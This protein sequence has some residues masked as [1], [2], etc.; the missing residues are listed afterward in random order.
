M[1]TTPHIAMAQINPVVGD[2]EYNARKILEYWGNA[3]SKADLVVFPELSVSGY[4]PEDLVLKPF[5]MEKMKHALEDILQKSAS[6]KSAALIGCPWE[7]DGKTHNAVHLIENSK[8]TA[9]VTKHHLP[10]YGVFDEQR[11]F[12][13]GPLPGP[14]NF[15][16]ASLGIMI[17]EDMW[18]PDVAAHLKDQGADLFIVPNAS[19]FEADKKHERLSYAR[20]R[21]AETGLK[22]IYVNQVGGQD[23]LVF[24]GHSFVMD[25]D[26]TLT[27]E[28]ASFEEGLYYENSSSTQVLNGAKTIYNAL[29]LGLKDYV[30]KNNFP[31]VLI[32]LSGGIDSALAAVLAADALGPGKVHCV[33]MPSKFTS[34]DSLEDAQA[35]A[36]NLG[37][38]LDTV[39]IEQ[40]VAAFNDILEPHFGSDT[41][42]TTF[43]NIQPRS[44]G[45]IL[46]A[47]SNASD[48]M[49]LST[50]NKSEMAVGYA[51]L[52]GD[53]CGGFNPLKDIYKMQVYE[54]ARWRNTQGTSPVIPERILTKAP[55]AELKDNQT[56]Q[57]T[58]PPY[59]QLDDILTCLIEEDM[60]VNDIAARGH[61]RETIAKVWLMLDRAEYKRRQA[62]P[63]IKITSRA[64]GRDRR[65]PITNH[66]VNI[67]E[68]SGS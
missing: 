20:E 34:D 28:S 38:R 12:T 39:S 51:T 46:M 65:Y 67:V 27:F 7:I 68:K 40:P 60:S 26:G 54:L 62:P 37:V 59:D 13:P 29:V 41:P 43:E 61:D 24:D 5:F 4:P 9:T 32:G 56:D 44:R 14:V 11:I 52:Y 63:G 17:C 45:L 6:F 55:T 49:V 64:F 31:G 42:P 30:T 48:Y 53:M 33:M 3:E 47:L 2:L 15:R 10:N 19:P 1:S 57:D 35:L 36:D 25:Q 66:F 50:G 58:L 18:F 22:L 16:G 21:V 8:I 23:E